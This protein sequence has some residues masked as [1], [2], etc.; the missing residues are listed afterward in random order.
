MVDDAIDLITIVS[1]SVSGPLLEHLCAEYR[2]L[3]IANSRKLYASLPKAIFACRGTSPNGDLVYSTA[4][5]ADHWAG[6]KKLHDFVKKLR[7]SRHDAITKAVDRGKNEA[8]DIQEWSEVLWR[9]RKDKKNKKNETV[10]G[11]AQNPLGYFSHL[12]D[13]AT[14]VECPSF[15]PKARC[16]RCQAL[17]RYAVPDNV[18]E[19]EKAM[20][21]VL[22][23]GFTCAETYAHFFCRA[24]EG[25]GHA[26][27]VRHVN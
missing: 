6:F 18:K 22:F 4:A 15:Q 21:E 26:T 23:R 14:P 5:S 17:F 3:K 8:Y 20:P 12:H 25:Q 11:L 7:N 9:R 10:A 13:V 16:T 27:C 24:L 2:N 1:F 19:K